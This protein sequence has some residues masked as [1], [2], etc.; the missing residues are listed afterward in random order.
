MGKN[1]SCDDGPIDTIFIDPDVAG[2]GVS[3]RIISLIHCPY[4]SILHMILIALKVLASFLV[5][6]LA[7]VGAMYWA[8]FHK[9][10]DE[11]SITNLDIAVLNW[12]HKFSLFRK[13]SEEEEIAQ[14]K[15]GVPPEVL[16]QFVLTL[17]DQQPE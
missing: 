7:S 17:S 4:Y 11:H 3:F 15:G 6:S 5:T 9:C 8:Y 1:V 2:Y 16:Q 10:L 13:A 14:P 12:V